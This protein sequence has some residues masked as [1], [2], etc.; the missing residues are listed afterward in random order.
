MKYNIKDIFEYTFIVIDLF[1]RKF[2][3]TEMQAYQYLKKYNGISFIEQNYGILHTLDF[4]EAVEGVGL[5]CKK[6][7]GAL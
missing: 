6:F 1:S 4:S 5:Y 3:L 7:G 2:S